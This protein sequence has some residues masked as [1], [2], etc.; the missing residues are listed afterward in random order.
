MQTSQDIPGLTSQQVAA[1]E[2]LA[3]GGSQRQAAKVAG[4]ST[5]TLWRWLKEP[6]FNEFVSSLQRF[7][8][9]LLV[10]QLSSK[11][12]KTAKAAIDLLEDPKTP[13]A[14]R[15][16]AVRYITDTLHQAVA[17]KELEKRLS[18]LDVKYSDLDGR[19]R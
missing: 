17:L 1:A 8:Y 5:S 7:A 19:L 4:V 14:V 15:L 12:E 6:D 18:E 2:C 3:A 13:A 11:A 10:G 16:G 9:G